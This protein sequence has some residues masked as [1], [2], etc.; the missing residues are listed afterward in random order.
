MNWRDIL[1]LGVL[2][3]ILIVGWAGIFIG[4]RFFVLSLAQLSM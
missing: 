2:I 3:V 4:T 1:D